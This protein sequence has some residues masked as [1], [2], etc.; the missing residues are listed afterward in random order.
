MLAKVNSAA[1]VG[2]D[3][4]LVEVEVDV[5]SGL[6]STT[7]VGLP[8]TAVQESRERV[9]SAI[10]NAGCT[11]PGGRITVNLAP[12]DLKKVGPAYDLPIA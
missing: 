12:A 2:L 11:F 6:P 3:G 9:R 7:I 10:R 8:D 5:T 4:Q 1:V